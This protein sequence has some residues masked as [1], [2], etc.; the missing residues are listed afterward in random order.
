VKQAE[1]Q[2]QPTE[3]LPA[4]R[5]SPLPPIPPEHEAQIQAFFKEIGGALVANL[6]RNVLKEQ[7]DAERESLPRLQR[8]LNWLRALRRR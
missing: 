7:A 5:S 2:K 3:G 6:N 8:M 1:F 4:P